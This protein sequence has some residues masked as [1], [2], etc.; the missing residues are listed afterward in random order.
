MEDPWLD[1]CTCF[2]V[3]R[4]SRRITNLYDACLAPYGLTLTQYSLLSLLTRTET[5]SQG[6]LARLMGVD[7]TTLTRTLKPM[8]AAGLLEISHDRKDRRVVT[9]TLTPEGRGLRERAIPGWKAAQEEMRRQI[10]PEDLAEL[11][12]RLDRGFK[13][14]APP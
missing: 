5:P 1:R 6:D 7:R 8:Q 12:R 14:L 13:I 2:L 3:R 10:G 4:A 9:V 11:N